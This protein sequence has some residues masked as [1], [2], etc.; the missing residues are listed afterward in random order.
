MR[1]NKSTYG[2]ASSDKEDNKL[3]SLMPNL[4]PVYEGGYPFKKIK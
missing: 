2:N 3:T 4:H 1:K